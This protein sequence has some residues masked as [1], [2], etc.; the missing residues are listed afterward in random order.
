MLGWT[1]IPDPGRAVVIRIER[2]Q[3]TLP[4]PTETSTLSASSA[5]PPAAQTLAVHTQDG[6]DPGHAMDTSA[7]LNQRYRY[8][9]ERVTTLA[10]GGQSVEIQG[11]PSEPSRFRPKTPFHLPFPR[12]WSPSPIPLPA[13]LISPGYPTA[14]QTWRLTTSIAMIFREARRPGKSRR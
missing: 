6:I 2:V 12:V 14:N 4:A 3:L 13:R 9:L 5:P 10:P 7:L 8:T 11:S 1:P